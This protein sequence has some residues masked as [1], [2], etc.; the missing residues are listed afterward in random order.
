MAPRPVSSTASG[1]NRQAMASAVP[2]DL[3]DRIEIVRGGNSVLWGDGA[4]SGVVNV[5]LKKQTGDG[6]RKA[7]LGAAV[8]SFQGHEV[9]ASGMWGLGAWSLDASGK[10]VRSA[11]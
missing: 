9:S 6:V 7:V 10:R 3:I 4:S 1:T 11:G 5:I 8:E 2:L